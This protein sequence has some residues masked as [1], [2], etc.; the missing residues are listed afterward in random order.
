MKSAKCPLKPRQN[1]S[2][3][4]RKQDIPL[5]VKHFIAVFNKKFGKNIEDIPHLVMDILK[6]YDW[7]GNIRELQNIQRTLQKTDWQISG[8]KGA[9]S[10][11]QMNP[12]TLRS[13]VKKLGLKKT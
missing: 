7:P 13:R 3:F 6:N 2:M 1:Y 4:Y 9:A 5:L 10:I 8:A 12:S 11:L